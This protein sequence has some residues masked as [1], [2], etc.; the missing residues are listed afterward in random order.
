M[1]K[2]NLKILLHPSSLAERRLNNPK[3]E[4]EE[5]PPIKGAWLPIT[6]KLPLGRGGLPK[7]LTQCHKSRA[8]LIINKLKG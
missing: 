4:Q 8:P 5:K 2:R 1:M 3:C 7:T 6:G